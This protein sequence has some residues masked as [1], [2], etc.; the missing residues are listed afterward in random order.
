MEAKQEV[1]RQES[2]EWG[3]RIWEREGGYIPQPCYASAGVRQSSSWA[4]ISSV[5]RSARCPCSLLHRSPSNSGFFSPPSLPCC[6]SNS[7]LSDTLHDHEMWIQARSEE[8]ED[9]ADWTAHL[10]CLPLTFSSLTRPRQKGSGAQTARDE[11]H[12][13]SNT[14]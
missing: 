6:R 7:R 3:G 12:S 9:N 14:L 5:S 1:K 2:G 13:Y 10:P 4:K 8:G 11:I